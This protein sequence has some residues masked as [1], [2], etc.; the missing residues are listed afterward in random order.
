MA[1]IVIRD[2]EASRY[3]QSQRHRQRLLR[4]LSG[5]CALRAFPY[6]NESDGFANQL[7][8]DSNCLP[9]EVGRY[10]KGAFC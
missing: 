8:S 9:M 4:G 10:V 6:L 5:R 7:V 3:A 1:G 2:G